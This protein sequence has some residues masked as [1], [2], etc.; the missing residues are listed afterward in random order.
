MLFPF[1]AGM[2]PSVPETVYAAYWESTANKGRP[3][4]FDDM[5]QSQDYSFS[6]P[7]F[8]QTQTALNSRSKPKP[9]R[10]PV[11]V[12][13]LDEDNEVELEVSGTAT[14]GK[15]RGRAGKDGAFQKGKG[16]QALFDMGS[17]EDEDMGAGP[18][19]PTGGVSTLDNEAEDFDLTLRS[20]KEPTQAQSPKQK[21]RGTKRKVVAEDSSDEGLTFGGFSRAKKRK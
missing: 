10:K 13:E 5:S 15:A 2:S 18:G 8:T 1:I 16:A 14:R 7:K 17:E 19:A 12:E 3:R 21:V 9:K 20:T 6:Q 4:G 11:V